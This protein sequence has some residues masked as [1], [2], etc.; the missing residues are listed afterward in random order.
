MRRVIFTMGGKGGVGKTCAAVNLAEYLL[1]H[2]VPLKLIDCDTE[3]K[4]KGSL[5]SFFPE[6]VKVNIRE[7]GGMDIFIDEACSSESPII[8]ADLGAGSGMDVMRWF[9]EMYDASKEYEIS[10][11][12]IASLTS[13]PGSLE[14]LFSWADFLQGKIDYL[15]VKNLVQGAIP[16]WESGKMA[17]DFKASFSP[18][19]VTIPLMEYTWQTE[20]ENHG[21][22]ISKALKSDHELFRKISASIRLKTWQR[23]VFLEFDKVRELLAGVRKG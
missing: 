6:A 4:R 23:N 16:L 5:K 2:Q 17:G 3:N 22:T 18:G 11:L 20:L 7:F 8:L 10:F 15:V 13:N 14:T 21:L 9:G 12:G 1:F 19:E